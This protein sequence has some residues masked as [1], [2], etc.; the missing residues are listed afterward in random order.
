[1]SDV[2]LEKR[3]VDTTSMLIPFGNYL[4]LLLSGAPDWFTRG[5]R[6]GKGSGDRKSQKADA[7]NASPAASTVIFR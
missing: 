4:G 5:N 3:L 2:G 1:M 7:D 6:S